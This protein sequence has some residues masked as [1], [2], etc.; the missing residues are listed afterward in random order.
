MKGAALKPLAELPN[1]IIF[2][3]DEMRG[4]I[5]T[6]PLVSLPNIKR[7]QDQGS[8]TFTQNFAVNP[9]CGPSRCCTFT[10]QYVHS[11]AHRSLYQL[12]QSHEINLF[13][14]LKRRGYE[15]IWIGRNDLFTKKAI[16]SSVSK[17]QGLIS[18]IARKM[19]K[20]IPNRTK[21][22]LIKAGLEYLLSRSKE[23]K[24]SVIFKLLEPYIKQNPYSIN[25]KFRNSFYFGERTQ[26]Q[27][28]LDPDSAI[29]EKSVKFLSHKNL[30]NKRPFCLFI[31]LNFPHPPYTV[32]NPYF[33]QIDRSKIN[34]IPTVNYDKPQYHN[35]MKI[36][37]GLNNLTIEDL[38]EIRA[39]YYGMNAK[40][41]MHL[42]KILDILEQTRL[43]SKTAFFFFADH[44][45]FAGDYGLTE[46]W[47]NAMEDCL[48]R[49]PLIIKIPQI[50]LESKNLDILTQSIDIFPTILEIA[51]IHTPYTHFGKSLL[52]IIQGKIK[53]HRE[54]VYAEGGYDPR[55]PQ[56][57][58]RP[59]G[60][61]NNN[62][63]GIYFHK[64]QIAQDIPESVCRTVMIRTNNRKLVLRS[65]IGETEEFYN[66]ETDPGETRNLIKDPDYQKEIRDMKERLLR[67]YLATS[68]NPHWDSKREI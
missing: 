25:D 17:H 51:D 30:L 53:N 44:G 34:L 2:M 33:S 18:I 23:A 22:R 57:F 62:L 37:Y 38:R 47:P 45:D 12:L 40:L 48:L 13:Q 24:I 7:L 27:A 43:N 49:I 9:V 56:C 58:E 16:K 65:I 19:L 54:V 55:E 5:V 11:N 61:I 32:E 29:I 26:I 10:G 68:D 59:I 66:L 52:P 35:L 28:D 63:T 64:I 6:N 3:P 15:V 46:K 36:R 21:L 41:D 14:L 4:D 8:V 20:T 31:A 39:T 1:I 42:G 60:S 67:W 50:T